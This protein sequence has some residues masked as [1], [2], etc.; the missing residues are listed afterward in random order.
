MFGCLSPLA[1]WGSYKLSLESDLRFA[2]HEVGALMAHSILSA[3]RSIS[4]LV[5]P[6]LFYSDASTPLLAAEELVWNVGSVFLVTA[7][8]LVILTLVSW[9]RMRIPYISSFVVGER[10]GWCV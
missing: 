6:Y 9:S 5:N 4:L 10:V 8:G 2:W 3:S 1:A 7:F